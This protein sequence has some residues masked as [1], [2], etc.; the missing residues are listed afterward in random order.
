MFSRFKRSNG[1]FLK[2]H[3]NIDGPVG[4][5]ARG[6]TRFLKENDHVSTALRIVLSGQRNI[7]VTN[8][9]S[10]EFCGIIN[11][12]ILLN[13]FGGG[14][15]HQMY[16]TRKHVTK[17]P[18]RRL[19]ETGHA[20]IGRGESIGEALRTFKLTGEEMLPLIRKGELDGMITERDLISQMRGKTGVRVWELMTSKPVVV[21]NK[22]PVIDVAKMLVKGGFSRM[23]VVRDSF[24]TG[25]IT[26][27]DMLR[28]CKD[29]GKL[30]SLRR[31]R[32][33]VERAMNR[34]VLSVNPREDVGEAAKVMAERNIAMLPVVED[35]QLIGV[36]TQSDI[37]DVM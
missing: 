31:D 2:K 21:R 3:R 28:Y 20:S 32:S 27:V 5:I 30:H 9:R 35:Y 22:N 4:E 36:L 26:P 13:Y 24:L 6:H 25:I 29:K 12:R 8:S 23:P 7:P 34:V 17:V 19:M 18:V 14:S 16:R 33:E 37:I 11:S 1:L 15:L 10:D